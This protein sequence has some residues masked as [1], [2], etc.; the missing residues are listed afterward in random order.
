[1]K[2]M[3]RRVV[4]ESAGCW[5]RFAT[6]GAVTLVAAALR[7]PHLGRESLWL[8]EAYSVMIARLDECSQISALAQ[9][10]S[11]WCPA[12]LQENKLL[13]CHPANANGSKPCCSMKSWTRA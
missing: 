5:P 1:M 12:W 10:D 7:F 13:R 4:S 8:D 2:A 9:P 3:F 11:Q 6:V